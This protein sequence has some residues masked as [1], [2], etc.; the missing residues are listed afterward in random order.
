ML[1]ALL[2]E[3]DSTL[4]GPI[5]GI[6]GD[7]NHHLTSQAATDTAACFLQPP[8][9]YCIFDPSLSH[10]R[11][12]EATEQAATGSS[13]PDS[14]GQPESCEDIAL[15]QAAAQGEA[16]RV[17]GLLAAGADACYQACLAVAPQD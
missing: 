4:D 10:L 11:C 12:M 8:P 17:Q 14:S 15:L 6:E 9:C 7:I 2:C 1:G 3:I 13:R 5:T 16:Q